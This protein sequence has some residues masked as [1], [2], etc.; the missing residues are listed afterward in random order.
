MFPVPLNSW[1]ITSSMRLP[2]STRAVAMM[3]RLPEPSQLRAD[4]K[5]CRGNW[6]ARLSTPPDMVRPPGPIS[7]LLARPRRVSESSRITTWRPVSTR[8]F[9]RSMA[10]RAS[11]MWES[12]A[13]SDELARTSA[14]T[15]LRKCVTSSGRSSM[16]SRM[17]C[18]SG[19]CLRDGLAEVLEQRRLPRLGGRDDEPA[20]AAPDG[21]DQV[22]HPEAH[23][24]RVLG[25]A[26]GLVGADRNEILEVGELLVLLG[27]HP[28]RLR[29]F[30]EHTA[31]VPRV[32]AEA[33]HLGPVAKA[34][35]PCDH[36]WNDDVF[37]RCEVVLSDLP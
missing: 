12:E 18:V 31:T 30:D 36:E 23:L 1:K 33:L 27:A 25:E 16:S 34:E 37:A 6:R 7:R 24:R 15:A 9:A 2:V 32:T 35:V 19:W 22:D 14:G 13:E 4:P 11:L 3:V 28:P 17:R 20:L 10:R 8:R 21:R 5:N 26:E 29:D